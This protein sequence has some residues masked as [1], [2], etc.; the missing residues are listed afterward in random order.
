MIE[1]Y[2]KIELSKKGKL[3]KERVSVSKYDIS[4]FH[5]YFIIVWAKLLE[6]E[7]NVGKAHAISM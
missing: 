2:S 5:V 3:L 4:G 1:R 7:L 6:M